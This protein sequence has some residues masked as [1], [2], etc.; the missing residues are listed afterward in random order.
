[1]NDNVI[2]VEADDIVTLRKR[3]LILA[4]RE[5]GIAADAVG[6]SV[7]GI[8][9]DGLAAVRDGPVVFLLISTIA[10]LLSA[11]GLSYM[12]DSDTL[13]NGR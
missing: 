5:P 3:F 13:C 8:E 12:P 4:L 10:V 9:P 2:R 7:L 11:A 1:M 6:V